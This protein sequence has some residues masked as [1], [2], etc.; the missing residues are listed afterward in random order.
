MFEFAPDGESARLMVVA[1]DLA[2]T[3]AFAVLG[4]LAAARRGLDLFGV[5]ERVVSWP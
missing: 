2:G 4:A 1:L 5:L 3:F